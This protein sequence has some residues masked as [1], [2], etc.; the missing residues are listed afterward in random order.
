MRESDTKEK[1]RRKT[2]DQ[3]MTGIEERE[4]GEE[5]Q[6]EVFLVREE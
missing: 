1:K 3:L 2:E 6:A 5:E 4:D